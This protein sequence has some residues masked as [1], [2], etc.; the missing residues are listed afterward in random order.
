MKCYFYY[1]CSYYHG[2]HYCRITAIVVKRKRHIKATT[3]INNWPFLLHQFWLWIP[4][5]LNITLYICDVLNFQHCRS[6]F[7][8]CFIFFGANF[9]F[10]CN[11]YM[12]VC[13]LSIHI[14]V[15]KNVAARK[16]TRICRRSNKIKTSTSEPYEYSFVYFS[17]IYMQF[18]CLYTFHL[19]TFFLL[20]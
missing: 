3:G 4:L 10:G 1:C 16:K 5:Y 7:W 11:S 9:Y 14:F 20:L 12:C 19:W 17:G 15:G 8:Y 2:C 13:S 18:S 6:L